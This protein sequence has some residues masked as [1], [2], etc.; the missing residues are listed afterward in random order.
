M[1]SIDARI[2]IDGWDLIRSDHVSDS[3]KGGVCI[4]YKEHIL[5]NKQDD[6]CTLDYFLG[7]EICSQ[8]EKCFLTCLYRS[9]CQ[10]HEELENFYVDFDLLLSNISDEIP[11]CSIIIGGFNA[12]TPTQ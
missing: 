9:S 11:I 7:T 6:I 4:Y 10:N 3:K 5:L 8:S 1:D 2:L 12:R